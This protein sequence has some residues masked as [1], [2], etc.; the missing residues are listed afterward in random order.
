MSSYSQEIGPLYSSGPISIRNGAAQRI[1]L[2]RNSEPRPRDN[3][4]YTRFSGEAA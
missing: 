3:F 4:G 2:L 1:G